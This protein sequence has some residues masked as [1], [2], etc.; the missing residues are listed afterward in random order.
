MQQ[1][2]DISIIC[3]TPILNEEWVLEKFLKAAS[4][5]ADYILIADQNSDDNSVKIA[6]SFEKVKVI[7]NDGDGLDEE[8]RQNLLLTEARKLPGVKK[9]FVVLD[10]DE[11]LSSNFKESKEWEL[12]LKSD[13]GTAFTLP[14][15][16]ILDSQNCWIPDAKKQFIYIDDGNSLQDVKFHAPRVPAYSNIKTIHLTEI[17]NL[18]LQY[19]PKR[20]NRIKQYWYQCTEIIKYPDKH[21]IDIFRQYNKLLKI[22]SNSQPIKEVWING[23]LN[24]Q[25]NLFE[26]KDII[27]PHHIHSI[28]QKIENHPVKTYRK[29]DI[30]EDEFFSNKDPRSRIDKKIHNWLRATQGQNHKLHN[31]IIQ[32]FIK[33]I[34]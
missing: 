14:W 4:L 27:N 26:C 15:V 7:Q 2:P 21:P 18:H 19:L 34:W 5:W 24:Q 13:P 8:Y 20:R 3:L 11:F 1:E 6:N 23:Y 12:I 32:K 31:R 33:F 28:N 17:V 22:K 16:H 30:W 9:I 10:C 29:L 25:I